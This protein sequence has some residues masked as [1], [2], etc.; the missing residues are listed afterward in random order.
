MKLYRDLSIKRKLVLIIVSISLVTLTLGFSAGIYFNIQNLKANLVNTSKQNARV[1]ASYAE[2]PLLFDDSDAATNYLKTLKDIPN[3]TECVIFTADSIVFAEYHLESV[4]SVTRKVKSDSWYFHDQYLHIY[5]VLVKDGEYLGTVFIK[6]STDEL[7]RQTAQTIIVFSLIMFV[8]TLIAA[9]LGAVFQKGITSPI[10]NLVTKMHSLDWNDNISTVSKVANDEVGT[11]YDG[12]NEMV[13]RITDS[14]SNLE[15]SEKYLR[16]TLNALGESVITTDLSGIIVGVNSSG[17]KLLGKYSSELIGQSFI[18]VITIKDAY[19]QALIQN[20]VQI[21]LSSIGVTSLADQVIVEN[22]KGDTFFM[23]NSAGPIEDGSGSVTGAVFVF[24]D[25]T[26]E[27]KIRDLNDSLQEKTRLAEKLAEDAQAA[28]KAKSEFLA[29]MSHEIRTPMNGVLGMN[30]LLLETTLSTSQRKYAETVKTSGQSLLMIINDILDFSK[31]EAG[32]LDIEEI[33]FDIIHVLQDFITAQAFRAEE[34]KLEFI[35]HLDEEIPRH[36]IGDP[37]RLVQILT[38]LCGNSLKF[39]ESGEVALYIDKLSMANELVTVRFM[40]R[41]TGI[42]VPVVQQEKLFESFTQADGSTTRKFGG[43]GLGLT[44]S[45]QL[46]GLMNGVI[47]MVSPPCVM[48][49]DQFSSCENGSVFWF[50]ISFQ[51]S[52]DVSAIPQYVDIRNTKILFVDD[53]NTNRML[54][55][56]QIELWGAICDVAPN[57]QEGLL[58]LRKSAE[59][60]AP[61]MIAILDMQMPEMDGKELGMIIKSDSVLS[62]TKLIMMTSI[63]DQEESK[64]YEELGFCAYLTKPVLPH[65]L[66]LCLELVLGKSAETVNEKCDTIITQNHILGL[67]KRFYD[68][69]LVEDN[70]VNQQVAEGMLKHFGARTTIANNGK[71]AVAIL[72]TQAFDLIFMD[73]QMPIM[74]GLEA[75]RSI[76]AIDSTVINREIPIIAMTA[77]A[78]QGDRERCIDAGMNDYIAKPVEPQNLNNKLIQWVDKQGTEVFNLHHPDSTNDEISGNIQIFNKSF[79]LKRIMEDKELLKD[80]IEIFL[81]EMPKELSL[82]GI[83][84]KNDAHQEI[85]KLGHKIKGSCLSISGEIMSRKASEIEDFRPNDNDNEDLIGTLYRDL[86]T[87]FNILQDRLLI[88]LKGLATIDGT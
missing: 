83:A 31:I 82:L 59:A 37:G 50:E 56:D 79:L 48:D 57:A 17:A 55:K 65:D 54:V 64:S 14:K 73:M 22:K 46:V 60:N 13:H 26:E 1:V 45:R 77:N 21:V 35:C 76:R 61:Y 87:D 42:G 41:D 88:E 49:I 23:A 63:G 18:D 67:Q 33:E 30:S 15:Q 36:L 9:L 72:E 70:L 78:M 81:K 66:H 39:T 71:E 29:T 19:S 80:L 68:I 5:N 75:T 10:L 69:L 58:E 53:N 85:N 20:P 74:D 27:K 2:I 28:S 38:N 86:L 34:K 25:L 7:K 11:L 47:G 40:V 51:K 32:K 44:I 3:I 4:E 43:T 6:V 24:M 62:G 84:I 12:F 8:V 16:T 52:L